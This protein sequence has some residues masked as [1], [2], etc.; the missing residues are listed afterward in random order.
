MWVNGPC[1][2]GAVWEVAALQVE[3]AEEKL[4]GEG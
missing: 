3:E 4:V 1:V 2:Q